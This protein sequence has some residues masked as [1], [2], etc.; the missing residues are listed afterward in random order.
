MGGWASRGSAVEG[1]PDAE[2]R[3]GH[4]HTESRE[5]LVGAKTPIRPKT[6]T[7][8]CLGFTLSAA[9]MRFRVSRVTGNELWPLAL[10]P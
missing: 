8:L 10:R 2:V 5:G 1:H 4:R 3:G 6:R 7:G 9:M